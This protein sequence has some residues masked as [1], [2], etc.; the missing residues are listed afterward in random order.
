MFFKQI[1][2][3]IALPLSLIFNQVMPVAYVPPDWKMA[4]MTTVYK[5]GASYDCCNYSPISVTCVISKLFERVVANKVRDHL[6]SN[7]M[8]HPAQH[9]FMNGRSTCT[10]LLESANDWTF[11]LQDKHQVVIVY[12]DFRK[13]FDVVSHKKLFTV[14]HSYG[15]RGNLFTCRLCIF[16]QGVHIVL[17]LVPS[18]QIFLL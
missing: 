14:L 16:S 1:S 18:C 6:I 13:A 4:V 17:R 11:Y 7:N 2:R 5:T 3:T 9:G 12:I 15:I 10:N 8:L